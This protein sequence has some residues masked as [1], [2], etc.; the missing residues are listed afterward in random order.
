[1]LSQL[2]MGMKDKNDA[3]SLWCSWNWE[4]LAMTIKNLMTP[5]MN[6]LGM[7]AAGQLQVA[8]PGTKGN[9][10]TAENWFKLLSILMAP[11]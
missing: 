7:L 5:R 1:M 3:E 4:Q 10:I 2:K 8:G 11:L 9:T 6:E